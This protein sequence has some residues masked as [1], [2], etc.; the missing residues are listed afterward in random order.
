MSL[1][2]WKALNSGTLQ[3]RRG[4]K[5]IRRF[6][7]PVEYLIGGFV[8]GN[9]VILKSNYKASSSATWLGCIGTGGDA[10]YRRLML[11]SQDLHMSLPRA[12]IHL[13][14]AMRDAQ[15]ANPTTVGRPSD[16]VVITPKQ[17]RRMPANDSVLPDLMLQYDGRDTEEV[18][19]DERIFNSVMA[20]LYLP[21]TTKEDYAKGLRAPSRGLSS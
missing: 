15:E 13:A 4:Q 18:D 11:R 2:E 21:G 6:F 14:E 17:V 7:L 8:R 9:G 1:E 3:Y 12:L 5:L 19:S 10:A 16:Y 20:A